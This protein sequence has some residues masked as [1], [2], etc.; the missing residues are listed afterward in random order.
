MPCRLGIETKSTQIICIK[1][2]GKQWFAWKLNPRFTKFS[3]FNK[4]GKVAPGSE[5]PNEGNE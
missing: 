4:G 2:Q 1:S 5:N 3:G